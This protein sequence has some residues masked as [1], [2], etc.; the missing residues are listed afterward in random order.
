MLAKVAFSLEFPVAFPQAVE[1]DFPKGQ[2]ADLK[3]GDLYVN[4]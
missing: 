1:D 4:F 3:Y 2:D